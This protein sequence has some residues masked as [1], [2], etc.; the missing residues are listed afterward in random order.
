M[1]GCNNKQ[2]SFMRRALALADKAQRRGEVP[3]GALIVA[4]NKIIAEG[5]NQ[6][7]SG[8]DATG[9]AEIIAIR[10][11]CKVMGN[12]RLPGLQLYVTLEPCLMCAGAIIHARIR[13]VFYGAMDPRAGAVTSV[14][15]AFDEPKL[16][17]QVAHAGGILADES[18]DK[19]RAFFRS[20]R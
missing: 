9:H 16:N 5:W 8:Q 17:H 12:Y 14:F 11:A 19:L 18:A 15:Q 1:T 10:A 3:V 13:Q 7:I 4:E 2:A 6:P 20:R